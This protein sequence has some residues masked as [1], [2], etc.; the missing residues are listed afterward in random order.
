[1]SYIVRN[2][3]YTP[4]VFNTAFP[5]SARKPVIPHDTPARRWAATDRTLSSDLP[6]VLSYFIC[7]GIPEC[8]L[9][10][11]LKAVV[12]LAGWDL[13]P[14]P[15]EAASSAARVRHRDNYHYTFRILISEYGH[16]GKR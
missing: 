7:Q 16:G 2:P 11:F 13:R 4:G 3:N 12:P 5:G 15:R 14:V 10:G 8:E 6:K 9:Y 1:M